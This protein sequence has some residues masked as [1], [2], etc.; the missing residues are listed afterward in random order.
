MS[1][2]QARGTLSQHVG[3]HATDPAG[4]MDKLFDKVILGVLLIVLAIGA[5]VWLG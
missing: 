2:E 4:S 3:K 1:K 5:L